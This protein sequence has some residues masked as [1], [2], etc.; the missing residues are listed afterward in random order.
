MKSNRRNPSRHIALAYAKPVTLELLAAGVV[1]FRTNGSWQ[2]MQT[3]EDLVE[4]FK[5]VML[6]K[7]LK[8]ESKAIREDTLVKKSGTMK[9]INQFFDL[10]EAE[11]LQKSLDISPDQFAQK[12]QK[13]FDHSKKFYCILSLYL[14]EPEKRAVIWLR[15]A[16]EQ[17]MESFTYKLGPP[18]FTVGTE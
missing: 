14:I 15:P 7:H 6:L 12:Y 5:D 18:E 13:I 1:F 2:R 11:N 3:G 17:Q 10:T 4:L 16:D 8:L 9:R